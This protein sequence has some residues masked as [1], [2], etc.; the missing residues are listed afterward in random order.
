MQ[1]TT[2]GHV[3]GQTWL[4]EYGDVWRRTSFGVDDDLL[5][6]RVGTGVD[7]FSTGGSGET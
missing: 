3:G 4:R 2:T 7:D 5:L 6:K 1:K